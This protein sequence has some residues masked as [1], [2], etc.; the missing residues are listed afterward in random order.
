VR[1]LLAFLALATAGL[2]C[3][4]ILAANNHYATDLVG[5][6]A[7]ATAAVLC[8]SLVVDELAARL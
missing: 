5:G 3:V 1:A 4:A 6:A 8:A 7:V 2:V